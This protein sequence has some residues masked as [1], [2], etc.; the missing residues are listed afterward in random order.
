[1]PR[2]VT[3]FVVTATA[4]FA[5]SWYGMK[6]GIFIPRMKTPSPLSAIDSH[7]PRHLLGRLG[8]PARNDIAIVREKLPAD[9]EVRFTLRTW[10][11]ERFDN[12]VKQAKLTKSQQ[13]Q[14]LSVLMDASE[15]YIRSRSIER[16]MGANLDMMRDLRMTPN[17]KARL[18][19]ALVDAN[20]PPG[21]ARDKAWAEMDKLNV[22]MEL[23][24]PADERTVR[25]AYNDVQQAEDIADDVYDSFNTFLSREQIAAFHD[26]FPIFRT[27]VEAPIVAVASN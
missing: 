18:E 13:E 11:V 27:I 5:L 4:V 20:G 23:N 26:I 10:N 19:K 22:E 9:T 6:R 1:V 24:A 8:A 7:R 17:Q 14:A 3:I 16:E 15:N 2:L 25:E 12:W 21:E